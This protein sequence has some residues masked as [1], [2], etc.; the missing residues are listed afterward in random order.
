MSVERDTIKQHIDE[1]CVNKIILNCQ[2]TMGS[3]CKGVKKYR[4]RRGKE[5]RRQNR[6][7]GG[8]SQDCSK[9]EVNLD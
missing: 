8:E 5:R 4:H 6:R 2:L 3:Y 7:G 9:A 1:S